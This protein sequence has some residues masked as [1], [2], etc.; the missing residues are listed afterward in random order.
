VTLKDLR[1]SQGQITIPQS[2]VVE[3]L[4]ERMRDERP[5]AVPA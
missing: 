3:R 4:A 5:A 1:A 2:E